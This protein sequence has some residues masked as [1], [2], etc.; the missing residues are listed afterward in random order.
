MNM[1]FYIFILFFLCT[2][3]VI[4]NA[5]EIWQCKDLRDVSNAILVTATVFK[6]AEQGVIAVAGTE[7][8]T[9]YEVA[10]FDRQWKFGK[11]SETDGFRYVFRIKPN[12]IA[13]YFDIEVAN[14]GEAA[15]ED[16]TIKSEMIF[17]CKQKNSSWSINVS[18]TSGDIKN[19]DRNE[20]QNIANTLPCLPG[21]FVLNYDE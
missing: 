12:G 18:A 20:T 10:G 21:F 6:S 13:H 11:S 19:K 5:K 9:H 16:E 4:A 14:K 3:P 8:M 17:M 15:S 1:F 7:H 2:T